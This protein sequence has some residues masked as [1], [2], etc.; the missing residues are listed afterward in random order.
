MNNTDPLASFGGDVVDIIWLI[1]IVFAIY[2]IKT[3]DLL[4]WVPRK[5]ASRK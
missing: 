4:D 2:A 1:I 5:K 3:T